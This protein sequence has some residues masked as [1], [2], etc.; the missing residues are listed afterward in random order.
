MRTGATIV[1][2]HARPDDEALLTRGTLALLAS[3]GHRTLIV[4]ASYGVVHEA[5]GPGVSL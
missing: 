5:P 3:R 2:V 4:V 1:A